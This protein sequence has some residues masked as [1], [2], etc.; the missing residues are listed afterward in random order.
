[1]AE[2]AGGKVD[3]ERFMREALAEARVAFEL[4][5]VPIG[6]VI[7]KDG[8][9]IGRGHNLRETRQ[10]PTLHAEMVAIADAAR[11]LG[12]WRLTGSIMYV[13]IE[14]CPMCAGALVMARVSRLVYG[15]PDPKAGAVD[16]L[17]DVVRHPRFNHQITVRSGVL[18]A[19]S[20]ALMQR[21]FQSLRS[22]ER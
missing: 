20:A 19:E 13:T 21:F 4:G 9:I 7:V 5:E 1:M 11:L 10:D 22:D 8:R 17:M 2:G 14:P 3:D 16:T 12:A 6:A 18:E 15:A